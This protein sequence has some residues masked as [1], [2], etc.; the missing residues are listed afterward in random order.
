[1][2]SESAAKALVEWNLVSPRII[3]SRFN[4]K[5]RNVTIINCYAPTNTVADD[6]KEE[7]Y[8]SLQGVLDHTQRYDIKILLGDFKAKKDLT[9]VAR[10]GHGAPWVWL[11]VT[12]KWRTRWLDVRVKTRVDIASDHHL[13]SGTI[14][15][16]RL[17]HTIGTTSST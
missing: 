12:R 17:D 14:T 16:L 2:L 1:M 6:Q 9:T 8:S 10:K 15:T 3:T 11:I 5:G 7:L 4:S 13:N